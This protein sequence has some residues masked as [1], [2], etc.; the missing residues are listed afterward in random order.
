MDLVHL[1]G[2]SKGY[3]KESIISASVVQEK[4]Y[5]RSYNICL[6]IHQFF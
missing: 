6:E 2:V 5:M 1:I 3:V 4:I